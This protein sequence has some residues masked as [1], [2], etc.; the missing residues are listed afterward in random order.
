VTI[1]RL[2]AFSDGVFAVAITLLALDL[3]VPGPGHGGLTHQLLVAWPNYAAYATSFLVIGI[4]W[5][6]HHVL[7]RRFGR[8]DRTLLF[9][10]LALLMFITIIPVP[11]RL[12]AAYLRQGGW[13]AK[14]AA[15]LYG[16]VMEG[17]SISFS[18]IF[19]W[20]G[21]H[22]E[23]LH[24]S[25]HPGRHRSAFR[26]FG[27][28]AVAYLGAIALAFVAPAAALAAHFALAVFYVF[29]RTS[30]GGDAGPDQP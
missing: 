6:N 11:T 4:I 9:F 18:A 13:D 21:R 19:V 25:V 28:G 2:E 10:N 16:G 24:E 27:L 14:V 23:L 30:A 22:P 26:Q 8:A 12:L 15:A 3:N 20:G 5:V 17:M 1:D 29:D 7:F